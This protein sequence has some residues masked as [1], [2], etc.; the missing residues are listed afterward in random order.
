MKE[1]KLNRGP[2]G[3]GFSVVGGKGSPHGDY[4][5][6]VKNIF[7]KG[8]AAENGLLNR[9]DQIVAVNELPLDGATHEEAVDIL[10]SINGTVTLTVI[11]S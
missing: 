8:A 6:Y 11:S 9:G 3:L 1:I 10:K 5:I 2:D 4:P 7:E